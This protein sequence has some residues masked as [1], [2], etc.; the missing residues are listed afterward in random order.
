MKNLFNKTVTCLLAVVSLVLMCLPTGVVMATTITT[1]ALNTSYQANYA[2]GS[3][4]LQDLHA[5]IFYGAEFDKLFTPIETNLSVYRQALSNS[6]SVTQAGQISFVPNGTYSFKPAETQ[7]YWVKADYK[8]SSHAVR[9]T[10]LGSLHQKGVGQADQSFAKYIIDTH[11]VPQ[12]IE[13]MELSVVYGGVYVAPTEGTAGNVADSM[14]GFKKVINLKIAASTVSPISTGTIPTDNADFVTYIEDFVK[15]INKRDWK[16][17][18]NLAMSLDMEQQFKEGMEEK[19]NTQYRNADD[20]VKLK[21]FPNITV[22]GQ[23][24]MT[25]STKIFCSPIANL[26]HPYTQY[27]GQ[28]VQFEEEDR[29]LKAWLDKDTG[30]GT[31][32][33]SRLYTNSEEVS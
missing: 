17:P 14:H 16:R 25:G 28:L 3:K 4:G 29:S 32:D 33:D 10:W 12:H 9:K 30:Y 6:T 23:V 11:L 15:D 18:M 31:I 2:D 27:P 1:T 20:L 5:Q 13:D 19:Y 26:V 21:H 7:L 8:G 24:A 22:S